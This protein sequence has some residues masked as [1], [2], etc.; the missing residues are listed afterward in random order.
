VT[1]FMLSQWSMS[2]YN[3][4]LRVA[5][6]DSPDWWWDDIDSES[7]VIVLE[8]RNGEL[9][10]VGSVGGL[11]E[12]ERIY[13]VRFMGDVGYVVTF[14]Q[15]DPLYTIDLS[16]PGNPTVAGE[17]KILGYS[18]YLHPL[19]DG[20]L[21]GIGQDATEEGGTLGTQISVFDVN[22]LAN[23]ELLHKYTLEHGYSEV[24]YDHHAFLHW[25]PT[26]LTVLPVQTW[27]WDEETETDGGFSGAIAV[28][29]DD[30]GIE[31]LAR[32]THSYSN[33]PESEEIEWE[34]WRLP[35]RR[36]LVV[37]DKLLTV[38][39]GGILQSDLDT[40]AEEAWVTFSGR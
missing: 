18:A 1:G 4:F 37:G 19:G 5:T 15:T 25:V 38:S 20:L 13:S 8:D 17:L 6:T 29:V 34:G 39:D 12:G 26:G 31:E 40:L 14:R 11:G 24:E 23:P 30:N 3:G 21:L 32:I 33:D 9:V 36:S 35:I 22:D 28:R 16:D 7:F 27:W 10:E 2:E